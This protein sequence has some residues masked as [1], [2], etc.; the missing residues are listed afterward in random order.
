MTHELII[1]D[2]LIT[3]SGWANPSAVDDGRVKDDSSITATSNSQRCGLGDAV[4]ACSFGGLPVLCR[5]SRTTFECEGASSNENTSVSRRRTQTA[6]EQRPPVACVSIPE[7]S[8]PIRKISPSASQQKQANS[9]AGTIPGAP[10]FSVQET[11]VSKFF[12]DFIPEKW[13]GSGGYGV[14]FNCRNRLDDRSYAVKRV[15]VINSTTAIE[16]V[17]REAR[18][19]ALLDHPGIIRY[20]HTWMEKPP[21]GW[22]QEK[23]REILKIDLP[24]NKKWFNEVMTPD[25]SGSD[26]IEDNSSNALSWA[27][28]EGRAVESSIDDDSDSDGREI[29]AVHVKKDESASVVFAYDEAAYCDAEH[30]DPFEPRAVLVTS[31]DELKRCN[32]TKDCVYLYI[33]MED[34]TLHSWLQANNSIEDRDINRMRHWFAQIVSAIEYIHGQGLIHRDLKPQNIFFSVDNYLKIG[35][36][37]LATRYVDANQE[38]AAT[39][40]RSIVVNNSHTNDVGTRLYMSPEQIEKKPYSEKIDIFS[41][42]LVFTE[43]LIPFTTLMER[44]DVLNGVQDGVSPGLLESR[45]VEKEFVDWL[46]DVDPERRPSAHEIAD[47]DYLRSEMQML[48]YSYFR[49]RRSPQCSH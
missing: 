6:S 10:T 42:G 38:N 1:A 36:L 30:A 2:E 49:E 3:R 7:A 5:P 18:A 44:V 23:D 37:G 8:G 22:Q 34:L 32:N 16:R 39:E 4:K 26:Y 12:E 31:A 33:Q 11:F 40:A 35:D 19:M 29:T 24:A 25:S 48:G 46:T 15:A 17:K 41:L 21:A 47:S 45:P 28:E 20:F 14:V 27:D 43:L 13:L 9:A